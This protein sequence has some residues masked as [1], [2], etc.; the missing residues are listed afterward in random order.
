MD[1]EIIIEIIKG[2]FFVLGGGI[3]GYFIQKLKN[4]PQI[5]THRC[6]ISDLDVYTYFDSKNKSSNPA[7]P[8]LSPKGNCQFKPAG[9]K[10][11][12]KEQMLEI[13]GSRCYFISCWKKQTYERKN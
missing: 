10:K 12:E 7:C 8:Y 13:Q 1:K 9:E 6:R 4:R 3:L 5:T 11:E 2:L